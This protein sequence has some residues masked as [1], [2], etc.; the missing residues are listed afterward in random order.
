MATQYQ[1]HTWIHEEIIKKEG[2]NHMELGIQTVASEL[3]AEENAR[4]Q[5]VNLEETRAKGIEAGLRSDLNNEVTRATGIEGGLRTDITAL[6]GRTTTAEN[7]ITNLQSRMTT[8]ETE[9]IDAN[10]KGAANGVAQLDSSG[11]IP[12]TQLPSY[13]DDVLEGTANNVTTTAAGTLTADSF[14]LTGESSPCTPE[15]GKTYVDTTSNV[16]FRWTG[17]VFVSMGS[18]LALGET[19]YTAYRGDRGKEA[20]DMRH[21][22]TNKAVLDSITQNDIDNWNAGGGVVLTGTLL[23]GQ[24]SVSITD[25]SI[26]NALRIE[27]F[28]ETGIAPTGQSVSGNVY[29]ATFDEQLTD[30]DIVI[31]VKE[32]VANS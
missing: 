25:T 3:S 27:L 23:A 20:Y 29:T 12:S 11:K 14:T 2:L 31:E 7:N 9:K 19:E 10:E 26:G 1:A 16:Q 28:T 8:V 13:V 22:H 4:V 30:M 32:N 15:D 18:Y 21:T 5:D 24:T 17:S 6:Q